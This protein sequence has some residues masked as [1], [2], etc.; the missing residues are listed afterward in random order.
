MEINFRFHDTIYAFQN[1]FYYDIQYKL[2]SGRKY[3]YFHI[4][5]GN[6]LFYF[7]SWIFLKRA[8]DFELFNILENIAKIQAIFTTFP[9][10]FYY[11]FML[12]SFYIAFTVEAAM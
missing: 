9:A 6:R 4:D 11:L 5:K 10:K 7:F 2:L 12:D 3:H 1:N 8:F